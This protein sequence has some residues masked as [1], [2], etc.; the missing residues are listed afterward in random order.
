[1]GSEGS[2]MC[3]HAEGGEKFGSINHKNTSSGEASSPQST[4][5]DTSIYRIHRSKHRFSCRDNQALRVVPFSLHPQETRSNL[6]PIRLGDT[7][8]SLLPVNDPSFGF[9][10]GPDGRY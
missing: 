10:Q 8:E 6:R 7:N 1:M 4:L 2:N 5:T 3:L 9:M